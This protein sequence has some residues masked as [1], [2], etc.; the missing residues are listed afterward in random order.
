[1]IPTS[2]AANPSLDRWV[3]FDPDGKVCIQFGKVE[4]GQGNMTALAQI[5]ADELDVSWDRVRLDEP[6][7]G[8][9]PD[10]GLTV[11]SMSIEISG[12]SVRQACAEVRALFIDRAAKVLGC[13]PDILS[14]KDGAI[15]L[16][17]NS[18]GLSYWSLAKD[19]DLKR[20][21]TGEVVPKT[22][23][24]HR[25]VGKSIAR[26]DLAPKVF[27]AAFIHDFLPEGVVHARVLRQPASRAR[28]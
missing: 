28:L 13:S 3:R 12:A 23:D 19:V 4:Y 2:L 20:P 26:A 6:A 24:A 8:H 25:I 16:D 27:G 5:G 11:G 21:A 14:I 7:T 15:I 10:E 18:S 17:G 22:P 1:M 9:A